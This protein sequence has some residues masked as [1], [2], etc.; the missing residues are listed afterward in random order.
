M[1]CTTAAS[2]VERSAMEDLRVRA[3]LCVLGCVC[4][5][6]RAVCD[7][8]A[9][10]GRLLMSVGSSCSADAQYRSGS[11]RRTA[12]WFCAAHVVR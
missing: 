10:G 8:A 6:V 5:T 11:V 1:R 9:P 3:W 7:R 12:F 2:S 4:L